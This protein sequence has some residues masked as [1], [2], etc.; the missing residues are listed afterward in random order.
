MPTTLNC[1]SCSRPLRVPDELLGRQ[2]KCPSCG[3]TFLA[4]SSGEA[5]LA[6]AARESYEPDESEAEYEERA[7]DRPRGRAGQRSWAE[8]KVRAPAV[9]LLVAGVLGVLADGFQIF[10]VLAL[11]PPVP[12]PQM[13]PW[14]N[15]LQQQAHSPVAAVF[16]VIFAV[17]SLVIVIAAI[18]MMNLRS[19]GLA[20]TGSILAMVNLGNGCCLLGLPFGIW[21]L[22]TLT[23]PEV[24]AAFE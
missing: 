9:C 17:L 13:P 18:K 15:D 5:A 3:T 20:L 19:W 4:T 12:D 1:P 6:P 23:N 10:Q 22:I 21:A 16:G 2:V 11:P 8:G 14:L 24:K 7:E